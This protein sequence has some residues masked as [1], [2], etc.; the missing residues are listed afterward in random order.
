MYQEISSFHNLLYAYYQSRKC[1]RY[2]GGI[3]QFGYYLESNIW[4]L[5]KELRTE[6]YLPSPYTY[7]M[8]HDPKERNV[9]AP[10]F[11]DRVVQHSLID[12]IEPMFDKQFIFDSYACRKDKGTHLGLARVKKFLQAAR[13]IY[14]T[15]TPIYCLRMDISKYF[16]SISWDILLPIVSKKISCPQTQRLIE[17]IVTFHRFLNA[18]SVITELV[19]PQ[20]RKG[21]PIGNLTSQLFANVYLNELDQYVKRVLQV[22]WYARYMDDFLIVHPDKTYLHTLK[23]EIRCFL[24]ENLHLNLSENKVVLSD[25]KNGVPFVGYRIFYDHVLVRGNTLTHIQRKLKKRK[26]AYTHGSLSATKLR[27]SKASVYGHFHHANDFYLRESMKIWK[28]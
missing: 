19:N 18:G 23:D 11:R 15:Q 4:K 3:L 12:Y 9:A 25:V 2:M 14:G 21:L 7:F 28:P 27:S 1:K 22:R 24:G 10:A 8:V 17:K 20:A 26:K 13:S 16:A 5:H 6:Q